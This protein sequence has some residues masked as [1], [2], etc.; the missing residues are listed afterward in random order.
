MHMKFNTIHVLYSKHT[1]ELETIHVPI[2]IIVQSKHIEDD[3]DHDDCMPQYKMKI[4]M[5]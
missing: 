3:Y 1:I 5:F 2:K 4:L